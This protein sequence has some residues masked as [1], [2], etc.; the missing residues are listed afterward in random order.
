L[1]EESI[2]LY[3][4]IGDDKGEI[5]AQISLGVAVGVA[6]DI[7]QS[8]AIL[9]TARA[10]ARDLGD[11]GRIALASCNLAELASH[12]RDYT[13]AAALWTES[14][15]RFRELGATTLIGYAL[16]GLG[17]VYYRQGEYRRAISALRDGLSRHHQ[18]RYKLGAAEALETLALAM[19]AM[20]KWTRGVRLLGAAA[21]LRER[22]GAPQSPNRH[23]QSE[24][25]A[26]Q[27]RAE[28]GEEAYATAWQVGAAM[29][30]DEAATYASELTATS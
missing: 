29:S 21:M 12:H 25:I 9:E 26:S 20:G 11:R 23:P 10:R 19:C 2:R 14:L 5:R 15:E 8:M 27:A 3:R 4:T 7:A 16:C 13:R 22:A 6:G 18:A 17:D 30:L 1:L 24:G 28:I